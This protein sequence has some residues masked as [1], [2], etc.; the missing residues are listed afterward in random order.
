MNPTLNSQLGTCLLLLSLLTQ[1]TIAQD[2]RRRDPERIH[3]PSTV[4]TENKEYYFFSTGHGVSLIKEQ[5][6]GR[7]TRT[8]RVFEQENLPAWHKEKVP[9]NRG[10]LWAPDVIKLK[11]TYYLYYS[12]SSFGKQTSAIG[13]AAG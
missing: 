5:D 13:I 11:D 12:V 1:L 10:H 2:F 8:A 7:W 4:Y 9:A 6:D 3:D